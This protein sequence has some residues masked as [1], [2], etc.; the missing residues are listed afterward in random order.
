MMLVRAL[1]ANMRIAAVEPSSNPLI[2]ISEQPD[3]GAFVPLQL[4]EIFRDND[5]VKKLINSTRSLLAELLSAHRYWK[6]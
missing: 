1:E 3:F 6:N 2:N 4:D 5:S